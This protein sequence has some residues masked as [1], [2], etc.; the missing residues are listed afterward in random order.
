MPSPLAAER[1]LVA[2]GEEPLG[3]IEIASPL[4]HDM[5]A[6]GP[7]AARDGVLLG[8][9]ERCDSHGLS[10]L[11]DGRVSRVHCLLVVVDGSLYAVDV[12]SQNGLFARVSCV[13]GFPPL[14]HRIRSLALRSGSELSLG[15]SLNVLRWRT[16]GADR[17]P[18]GPFPPIIGSPLL[19]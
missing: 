8:R 2:A 7:S 15:P 9:Y 6:L 17:A 19:H 10:A 4:G 1:S 12:A 16:A 11:C 13:P 14:E 18:G 3:T 5:V